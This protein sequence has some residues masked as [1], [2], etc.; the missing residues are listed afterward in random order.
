M[1]QKKGSKEA[2]ISWLQD[3]K[4]EIVNALGEIETPLGVLVGM[5]S[6]R[7]KKS[8]TKHGERPSKKVKIERTT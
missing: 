4:V 6:I 5:H 7:L 3:I 1:L 8:S 2:L